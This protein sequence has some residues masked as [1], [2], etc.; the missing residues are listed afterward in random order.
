[1]FDVLREFILTPMGLASVLILSV[2]MLEST[3][4]AAYQIMLAILSVVLIPVNS[5]LAAAAAV[6]LLLSWRGKK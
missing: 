2:W 4:S 1:M 6:G 5:Y 3:S